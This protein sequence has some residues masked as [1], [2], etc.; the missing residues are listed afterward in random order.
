MTTSGTNTIFKADAST[1]VRFLW[2]GNIVQLDNIEPTTTILEFL[3]EHEFAVGTKEGCNE[4]DCGACTIAVGRPENGRMQY[5]AINACIQFLGTL[6]GAHLITVEDLRDEGGNLHPVQTAMVDK[7]AAQCGFCT[8]GFVMSLFVLSH[9]G[10]KEPLS[11][12]KITDA[13]AGNLCRCT[14]YRPIID[15]AFEACDSPGRDEFTRNE[16]KIIRKLESI[17]TDRPLFVGTEDRFFASPST[18]DELAD[19]FVKYPN[20][21]LVAGGTD[22]GLWV[23][24][25]LREFQQV[26][27][28][29]AIASLKDCTEKRDGREIGAA[30][31]FTEVYDEL[32]KIDPDMGELLRRIGS[33][34][35][36]NSGTVGGNIANGSPIGDSPPALIA[37][38]ASIELRM[39]DRTRWIPLEKFFIEYGKQDRGRGEF[40]RAIHIPDPGEDEHFR[41][42]K[43]AK[44]FDQDISSVLGAM[45]IKLDKGVITDAR[46][47]YGG[48]AGTPMRASK[49][50]AALIG[51]KLS[52]R[53]AWQKAVDNLGIDFKPMTDQRSSDTYRLQAAKGILTKALL[54]LNTPDAATRLIAVRPEQAGASAHG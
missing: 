43:I 26:I 33:E 1:S 17:E 25:Q 35:I 16:T 37:L 9:R 54:E 34:Q 15:A 52:N 21:L 5:R 39:G 14:G 49:T 19:I 11:R 48:M 4:G 44:R 7:H 12:Q 10:N 32:A 47:A 36:R 51:T 50:E 30:C 45:V 3:R 28:L 42:F 31:T 27:Y 29:G 20:A 18:E 8:P 46:I 23:T 24:K 53:S 40:V 13:I 6:H 38:G 22:V 2:R 41:C